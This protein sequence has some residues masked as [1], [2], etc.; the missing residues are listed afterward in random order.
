VLEFDLAILRGDSL[1]P[2]D[3]LRREVLQQLYSHR[4]IDRPILEQRFGIH[5]N[6]YF[7]GALTRLGGLVE[8]GLVCLERERIRLTPVLGRLLVRVVAAVFDR[9]LPPQAFREG[10]PVHLASR[11]G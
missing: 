9:Y 3:R 2:D 11:V 4:A 8:D 10:L 5:F 7:A 1:T 6:S